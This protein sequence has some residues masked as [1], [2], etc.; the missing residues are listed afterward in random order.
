MQTA[1]GLNKL[2]PGSKDKVAH[3]K[4]ALKHRADEAMATL[5]DEGVAIESWFEV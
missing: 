2:K 1:A 5:K 4:A 3:W